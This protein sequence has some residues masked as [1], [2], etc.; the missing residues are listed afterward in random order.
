MLL[1][2]LLLRL[3]L[4]LLMLLLLRQRRRRRLGA[5]STWGIEDARPAGQLARPAPGREGGHLALGVVLV[6]HKGGQ[7]GMAREAC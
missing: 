7:E 6:L 4:L 1:L 5:A 2:R 3:L